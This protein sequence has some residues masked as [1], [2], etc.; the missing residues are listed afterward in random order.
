MA[1]AIGIAGLSEDALRFLADDVTHK[2]K[3]IAQDS[4]K[5]MLHSKRSRLSTQDM[6]YALKAKNME[7]LY[8]FTSSEYIPFRNASGG[9]REVYFVEDKEVDLDDA[10]SHALP[11]IPLDVALKSHWLAING[12]QPAVPENPPPVSRDLQKLEGIDPVSRATID[13]LQRARQPGAAG[14][15]ASKKAASR[16]QSEARAKLK[17]IAEHELSVEQQLYYKEITEASVCSDEGRR[18][19]AL[20]SIAIESGLHQML[21]RLSTFIS[22]GVKVNIVSN[23]LAILIYLMRML[24]ALM[25]NST[26]YLERYLHEL[27]P[28]VCSCIVSKQLCMRPEND[29]HWA[30]RDFSAKLLGQMCRKF[31]TN[32]NSIQTRIV[33]LLSDALN[34]GRGPLATHYGCVTAL[35]EIGPEVVGS[36]VL[37]IVKV[38]GERIR[39]ALEGQV[40]TPVDRVSAETYRNAIIRILTHY[41]KCMRSQPDNLDQY[42]AELGYLGP[43]VHAAVVKARQPPVTPVTV[44][45]AAMLPVTLRPA[46]Q[47]GIGP[48]QARQIFVP[49][50]MGAAVARFPATGGAVASPL[51][52]MIRATPGTMMAAGGA[53]GQQKLIIVQAPQ[54]TSSQGSAT[55]AALHQSLVSSADG[56][57]MQTVLK[58]IA[59]PQSVQP[60]QQ[61]VQHVT[62]A[63]QPGSDPAEPASGVA[64]AATIGPAPAAPLSS[65][66]Q[67]Q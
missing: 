62:A 13:K 23:N 41:F 52:P 26:L 22:E 10:I 1:E 6:D 46:S 55:S 24:K 40:V 43:L 56:K 37:P 30:L 5:F 4:M 38:E 33:K 27:I 58:I 44:S 48:G 18:T 36:F 63:L 54:S 9:G 31:T 19:D 60:I 64:A 28:A 42:K 8:G 59:P 34:N 20:H 53:S 25:D 61:T 2:L 47:P 16:R 17:P 3:H 67:V 49:S 45:A 32:T 21:P 7:P 11:K 50:S 14:G 57:S 39:T 65:S 66:G 35:A 51:S 15:G 29:N 12:V